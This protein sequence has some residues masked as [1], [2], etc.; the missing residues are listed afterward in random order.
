M[1]V[2]IQHVL[3]L[4]LITIHA[5]VRGQRRKLKDGNHYELNPGIVASSCSELRQLTFID[6]CK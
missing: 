3:L 4:S 5:M 2:L 6:I 1:A